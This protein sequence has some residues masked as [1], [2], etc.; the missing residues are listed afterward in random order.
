ML[1]S[2]SSRLLVSRFTEIGVGMFLN[3]QL[4]IGFVVTTA[5]FAGGCSPEKPD[6][7][8][9]ESYLGLCATALVKVQYATHQIVRAELVPYE[10]ILSEG[11]P[12]RVQCGISEGTY[13]GAVTFDALC[14]DENSDTC[15]KVQAALMD[16][17]VVYESD[18]AI[19]AMNGKIAAA[20]THRHHRRVAH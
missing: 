7:A 6:P 3:K 17:R 2:R 15:V 10:R 19:A 18:E 11:P 4:A 9:P 20:S 13:T 5:L 14:D 8:N 16:G 1:G 12:V